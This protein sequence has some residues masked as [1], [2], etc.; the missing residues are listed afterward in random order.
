MNTISSPSIFTWFPFMAWGYSLSPTTHFCHIPPAIKTTI[1]GQT[2]DYETDEINVHT[3]FFIHPLIILAKQPMPSFRADSPFYIWPDTYHVFFSILLSVNQSIFVFP[4]LPSPERVKK[5]S[6][7]RPNS[8][9]QFHFYNSDE[10]LMSL[11]ILSKWISTTHAFQG[12]L[13]F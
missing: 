12:C 13:S 4:Q 1:K 3:M 9:F 6:N 7:Q 2:F 10:D 8:L 5:I 11:R